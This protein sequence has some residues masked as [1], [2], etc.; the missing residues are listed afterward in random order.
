MSHEFCD[1]APGRIAL[2]AIV[3]YFQWIRGVR[4]H[5]YIYLFYLAL[6]LV[7][8]L[9][10]LGAPASKVF[11][12]HGDAL[13]YIAWIW[14]FKTAWLQGVPSD[15]N[16][17]VAAPF[18][19]DWGGVVEK[20]TIWPGIWLSNWVNEIF[21]LNVLVLLSFPLAAIAAYHLTLYLT[22][23]RSAAFISGLIYSFSPFHLWKSWAWIPLANIQWL[24]F[25]VLALFRWRRTRRLQDAVVSGVLF[26]VTL[27]CSYNYGLVAIGFTFFWIYFEV[28]MAFVTNRKIRLDRVAWKS[29]VAATV[30]AALLILPVIYPILMELLEL[31]RATAPTK[32]VWPLGD[33]YVLTARFT[34]YFLPPAS[35]W[36]Y[37][38]IEPID[39]PTT[40]RGDFTNGLFLGYSTLL[41]AGIGVWKCWRP[42]RFARPINEDERFPVSLLAVA[43]LIFL[44]F[45]MLPPTLEVDLPVLGSFMLKGPGYLGYLLVPWF[46]EYARLGVMV[47][48]ATAV[49]AGFG[50]RYLLD[51]WPR[52]KSWILGLIGLGLIVDFGFKSPDLFPLIIN[53]ESPPAVYRWLAKQPRDFTIAEYPIP[54]T[55]QISPVY[56]YYGTVHGKR[57]VNGHGFSRKADEIM[58]TLL[59]LAEP[60]AA[61]VLSFL[62][63]DYLVWHRK[64][65]EF[66]SWYGTL[67]REPINEKDFEFVEEFDT[68]TVY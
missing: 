16:P 51:R 54:Q 48:L 18:G 21:A 32:R 66:P 59:T 50:V 47:L 46:R 67:P 58:P 17:M 14:W 29:V 3:H 36:L 62:G 38:L 42:A 7:I 11:A 24:A 19:T 28:M 33:F 6:T 41:L 15:P 63:V 44:I 45:S 53:T 20:G 64:H 40:I 22:G 10:V 61:G 49:L 8:A 35:S 34:D 9:P 56:L 12:G 4:P 30:V 43:L 2:Y 68:A 23:N 37:P 26:A 65:P 25:Y 57:I 5:I 27:L 39:T 52:R 31:D 13:L 60:Q 55:S 1:G